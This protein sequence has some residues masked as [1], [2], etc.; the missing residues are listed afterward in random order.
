MYVT[1]YEDGELISND[2]YSVSSH[3]PCEKLK[4][5]YKFKTNYGEVSGV[6]KLDS[7]CE[8]EYGFINTNNWHNIQIRIDIESEN[9][10]LYAKQTVTYETDDGVFQ[11]HVTEASADGQGNIS[12]F[13]KG[14]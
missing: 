2:N 4:N 13:R 14:I 6:I 1:V 5:A 9:G 8:I 10:A 3:L 12:V 7:G 11:V